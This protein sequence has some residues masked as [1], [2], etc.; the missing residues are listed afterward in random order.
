MGDFS[1]YEARA[2]WIFQELL[3]KKRLNISDIADVIPYVN[4]LAEH[5]RQVAEQARGNPLGLQEKAELAQLRKDIQEKTRAHDMMLQAAQEYRTALDRIVAFLIETNIWPFGD[6]DGSYE[7][8]RL[9]AP[10]MV[11][12]LCRWHDDNAAYMDQLEKRIAH[13]KF[14]ETRHQDLLDRNRDLI[15]ARRQAE[16]QAKLRTRQLAAESAINSELA[17]L[18]GFQPQE[19]GPFHDVQE[20]AQALF[21]HAKAKLRDHEKEKIGD[22]RG[23]QGTS[24]VEEKL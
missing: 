16:E 23:E 24:S 18:L 10:E 6:S 7:V 22:G 17:D 14:I 21:A 19:H 13:L 5:F 9:H 12:K 8:R 11:Q 20:Y 4:G 1:S 15:E 2:D 3:D